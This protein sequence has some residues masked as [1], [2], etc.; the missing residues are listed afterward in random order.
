MPVSPATLFKT[1]AVLF[2]LLVPGH[3]GFGLTNVHPGLNEAEA[4]PAALSCVLLF[5]L[6]FPGTCPPCC[7][8]LTPP[9]Q[10]RLPPRPHRRPQ[11]VGRLEL[12]EPRP[13]AAELALRGRGRAGRARRAGGAAGDARGQCGCG[14]AVRRA[15][16]V[17]AGGGAECGESGE[18]GGAGDGGVRGHGWIRDI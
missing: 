11:P 7:P 4:K 8:T 2:A 16:R 18:S 13:R 10:R 5:P 1:S 17:G 12:L 14:S 3:I 6:L 9:T 15:G